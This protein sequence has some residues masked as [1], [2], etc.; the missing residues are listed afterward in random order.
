MKYTVLFKTIGFIILVTSA[1]D[2]ERS[3]DY[4]I[5][6][7]PE[8]IVSTGF[9]GQRQKVEVFVSKTHHPLSV[10][11]DSPLEAQVDLFED[12]LLIDQLTPNDEGVFLSTL[13]FSPDTGKE[14][15]I[16]VKVAGLPEIV[17]LPETIPEIVKIENIEYVFNDNNEI[18]ISVTFQDPPENN[19][20][21]L[22]VIRSYND[23]LISFHDVSNILF[24]DLDVF[25]DDLFNSKRHK[26]ERKIHL[27]AGRV[28]NQPIY[29]NQLEV[30]LIS[31]SEA[32][33]KFLINIHEMDYTSGDMF[34]SPT[35]IYSNIKGGYGIFAAYSE[36]IIK[37][38]I[39][40]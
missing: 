34:T 14:Y 4:E 9:I 10:E 37:I 16:R 29:Y 6:G 30:R 36:D 23:T 26:I 19:Y 39:E 32:G 25:N 21:G 40:R 11:E 22:K 2:I 7:Q 8:R 1:C 27:S 33:Y 17:S 13:G 38:E 5:P 12:N 24:K 31:L 35:R 15:S 18:L 3:L 28:D 20:Y